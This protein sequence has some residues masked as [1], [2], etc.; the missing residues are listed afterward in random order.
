MNSMELEI[1]KM[2]GLGNNYVVI[3]DMQRKYEKIY[4]KIA[5]AVS[6]VNFGIGSDGILVVNKGRL[7][8]YHMRIFNPD[9]SEAELS[10]NGVR[11]VSMYL[12]D[13]KMIGSSAR[14]EAGGKKGGRTIKVSIENSRYVTVD[15]G[16]G[17][18][19]SSKTIT[20]NGAKFSGYYATVGNPH[21]VIFTKDEKTAKRNAEVYGSAIEH[22]K[23]FPHGVN[24]EFA[25][26]KNNREI[27]LHVWERGT[28]I[29]IACGTGS[30][31]SAFTALRQGKVQNPV[32]V[33]LVGGYL[34]I[35]VKD[36][37]TILMRGPVGYI[38]SGNLYI[39]EVIKNKV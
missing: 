13:R 6:N 21:F 38:F 14:I 26:V 37:D 25:Y 30:C 29:T 39:D 20:A 12:H 5:K 4:P 24:V 3:E 10:G 34:T 32:K 35:N 8:K 7:A 15:M 31:A 23:A 9:G 16:K 33:K 11:I 19:I 36:D 2:Q 27:V 1:T 28:G 18:I 17:E 22:N